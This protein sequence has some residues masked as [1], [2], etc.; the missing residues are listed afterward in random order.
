M[1]IDGSVSPDRHCRASAG[2]L[3]ALVEAIETIRFLPWC[4]EA[5]F[6]R[7]IL[8]SPQ[9]NHTAGM[10]GVRQSFTRATRISGQAIDMESGEGPSPVR[11]GV[12][13][14]RLAATPAGSIFRLQYEFSSRGSQRLLEPLFGA[15]PDSMV[16]AFAAARRRSN[17]PR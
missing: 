3:Y 16:D 9:S 17:G 15:S 10:G 13:L 14:R 7:E 4:I 11:R 5:G 12:A 8:P 1:D 2:E 6:W